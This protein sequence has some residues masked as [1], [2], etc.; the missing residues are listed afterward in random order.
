LKFPQA[1][2]HYLVYSYC[3]AVAENHPAIDQLIEFTPEMKASRQAF[4]KLA[5][6]IRAEKYDAILDAYS[7]GETWLLSRFSKAKKRITYDKGVRK[8]LHTDV[9]APVIGESGEESITDRRL[10]LIKPLANIDLTK[11]KK[12]PTIHIDPSLKEKA[13]AGLEEA[14]VD[15]RKPLLMIGIFGRIVEK[16]WPVDYMK[17]MV[18]GLLD[19]GKYQLIFNYDHDQADEATDF[20][21]ALNPPPNT[22][23]PAV[24]GQ[25]LQ[26]LIYLISHCTAYIGNDSGP[27]HIAKAVGVPTFT[28]FS[29]WI[30]KAGWF[31]MPDDTRHEAVHLADLKPELY[32]N[33][34]VSKKDNVLELYKQLTPEYVGGKLV[35]FL[36]KF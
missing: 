31:T 28:I 8:W 13:I 2:I 5:K 19:S 12:D 32:K 10:S 23:Y 16:T 29:P 7:K 17:N 34:T 15:L 6:R 9:V 22:L 14:G 11:A 1:E 20:V 25:A 27:I 33:G 36:S 3:K 26:D 30:S 21:R 24:Y 4:I 18:Q 35:R